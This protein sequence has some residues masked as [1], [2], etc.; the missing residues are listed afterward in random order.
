MAGDSEREKLHRVTREEMYGK[1]GEP[2]EPLKALIPVFGKDLIEAVINGLSN[3]ARRVELQL[4]GEG[5]HPQTLNVKMER[6]GS[7]RL[8]KVTMEGDWSPGTE[9]PEG[10]PISA[11]FEGKFFRYMKPGEPRPIAEANVD[12]KPGDPYGLAMQGK[13]NIWLLRA[14]PK[15]FPDG[16]RIS[17]FIQVN[18]ADV[19]PGSTLLYI[20]PL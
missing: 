15:V 11:G 19:E 18:G 8:L 7:G 20:K 9:V 10:L 2:T 13:S 1:V 17:A 4:I 3:G 14:D 5:E 16:G 6:P 12:L